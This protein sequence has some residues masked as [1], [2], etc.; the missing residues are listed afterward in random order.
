MQALVFDGQLALR[1]VPPLQPLPG[2]ALIRPHLVGICAT[3]LEIMRGYKAF[4]GVLGHEWVGTVIACDDADWIGARVVGEI[5]VPCGACATCRRGDTIH[6]PQRTAMGIMGRDGALAEQ[7]VLP[8]RNLHRVPPSL[9]DEQA[10]FAEP[11]AA[12]LA[13]C[14]QT[15]LHPDDRVA[16]VG[17]GKLGLLVAQVLR[18]PGC[19]VTVVGRHPERWALLERQRIATVASVAAAEQHSYD[20]VVDCTGNPQGLDIARNLVRPRGTLVLK[21][22]FEGLATLDLSSVVVDEVHLVGSR[23]GSFAAALRLLERGLIE[24]APLI[25]AVYALDQA[26][27]AFDAARGALKTLIKIKN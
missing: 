23:C 13:I 4:H 5:N 22:T 19:D 16:V 26:L 14:D 20:V 27:E 15:H 10:V 3:D 11:L 24:T 6:C 7:I 12:A 1:D 2:E 21:S 25:S 17:D 9:C 18:L 8:V